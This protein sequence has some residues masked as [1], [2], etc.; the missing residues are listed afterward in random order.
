MQ[1][2]VWM[3]DYILCMSKSFHHLCVHRTLFSHSVATGP[4]KRK[5]FPRHHA[6]SSHPHRILTSDFVDV[7]IDMDLFPLWEERTALDDIAWSCVRH[8]SIFRFLHLVK[9][10]EKPLDFL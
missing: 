10:P 9:E 1:T 7:R 5:A 4:L 3:C 2:M 8:H 6:E